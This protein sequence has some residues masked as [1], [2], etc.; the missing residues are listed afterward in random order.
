MDPPR[1]CT[2]RSSTASQGAHAVDEL[3]HVACVPKLGKPSNRFFTKGSAL[4]KTWTS[5][6]SLGPDCSGSRHPHPTAGTVLLEMHQRPHVLLPRAHP[7]FFCMPFW[8]GTG[9]HDLL[10]LLPNANRDLIASWIN[11]EQGLSVPQV[12]SHC[13]RWL[14]KDSSDLLQLRF[15]QTRGSTGTLSLHESSP[16]FSNR[17]TQ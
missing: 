4:Q 9:D 1:G 3:R 7:D 2:F 16:S 15:A 5:P 17:C 6:R 10:K 13:R 14:S 8:I 11:T 12:R